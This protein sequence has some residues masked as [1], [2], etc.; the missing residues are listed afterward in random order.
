LSWFQGGQTPQEDRDRMRKP[1]TK[2]RPGRTI[3]RVNM[4]KWVFGAYSPVQSKMQYSGSQ[5]KNQK[6]ASLEEPNTSSR[7][8]AGGGGLGQKEREFL[9]SCAKRNTNRAMGLGQKAK[10]TGWCGWG[11]ISLMKNDNKPIFLDPYKEKGHKGG[12]MCLAQGFGL[13]K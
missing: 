4:G 7:I 3:A 5:T 8:L 6:G 12:R 1:T 10:T 9:S 13:S 2:S 11:T